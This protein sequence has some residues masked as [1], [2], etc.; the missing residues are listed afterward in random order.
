MQQSIKPREQSAQKQKESCKCEI[1]WLISYIQVRWITDILYIFIYLFQTELSINLG[2][3]FC[4]LLQFSTR[5]RP[6]LMR[7]RFRLKCLTLT[8]LRWGCF[9]FWSFCVSFLHADSAALIRLF[10]FSSGFRCV[11]LTVRLH[12]CFRPFSC[13][14]R[15]T[16]RRGRSIGPSSRSR[17]NIS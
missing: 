13:C 16:F 7:S 8:K 4:L 6:I 9:S 2:V 10:S 17:K 14:I 3:I 12:A 5:C 11:W 1:F 15:G